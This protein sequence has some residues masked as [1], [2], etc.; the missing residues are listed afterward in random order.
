MFV[1]T[2]VHYHLLQT[3]IFP[4][5]LFETA[6]LAGPETAIELFPPIE[7]LLRDFH[8]ADIPLYRHARLRL[9]ER[10]YDLIVREP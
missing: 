10:E 3:P 1:E 8:F 9:A 4:F 6:N 5:D 2:E 7:G